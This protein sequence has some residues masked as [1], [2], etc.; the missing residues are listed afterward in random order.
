MAVRRRR[1]LLV[2]G[3][4]PRVVRVIP[5]AFWLLFFVCLLDGDAAAALL[6]CFYFLGVI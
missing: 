2:R 1:L 3:Y 5:G 4:R 6:V